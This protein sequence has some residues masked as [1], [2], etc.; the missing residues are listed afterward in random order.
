M[1]CVQA[2]VCNEKK[3]LDAKESELESLL[4]DVSN[5]NESI[6]SNNAK[7]VEKRAEAEALQTEAENT[8][9]RESARKAEIAKAVEAASEKCQVSINT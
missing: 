4:K 9:T 1:A 7:S 8:R 3:A 2:R 6:T 5:L